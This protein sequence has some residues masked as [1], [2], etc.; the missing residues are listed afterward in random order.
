MCSYRELLVVYMKEM[1]NARLSYSAGS[2]LQ[3]FAYW[4][5]TRLLT[6]DAP[7]DSAFELLEGIKIVLQ[8]TDEIDREQIAKEID[9]V[10]TNTGR[11]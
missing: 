2:E 3:K 7:V 1:G 10:L 11:R 6:P 5:D 8:S 4:L 9:A